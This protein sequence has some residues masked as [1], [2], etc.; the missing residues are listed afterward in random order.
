MDFKALK[1][2]VHV[3][4]NYNLNLSDME[5][6]HRIYLEQGIDEALYS[7][8]LAGWQKRENKEKNDARKEGSIQKRGEES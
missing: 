5:K 1:G 4:K 7:A 3:S 2:K 8:F 6:L